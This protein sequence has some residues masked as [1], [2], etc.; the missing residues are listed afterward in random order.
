MESNIPSPQADLRNLQEHSFSPQDQSIWSHFVT[1][2]SRVVSLPF[3]GED[4]PIMSQ[5]I[6]ICPSDSMVT[7]SVL[8]LGA[9]HLINHSE[10]DSAEVQ[11]LVQTKDVL[12]RKV[13]EE[14]STRSASIRPLG[15]RASTNRE[16]DDAILASYILQYLHEMSEGTGHS[17]R[18]NILNQARSFVY[19]RLN[20]HINVSQSELETNL[21]SLKLSGPEFE[22]V[23]LDK[24]LL[25]LFAYHDIL[26]RVLDDSNSPDQIPDGTSLEVLRLGLFHRENIIG[27]H[28]GLMDI[29]LRVHILQC[30]TS[31]AQAAGGTVIARAVQIWQ[32]VSDWTIPA[33]AFNL[34]HMYEA[35]I[36]AISIWLLFIIY[37]GE[38]SEKVHAM[39]ARGLISLAEMD[40]SALLVTS[41]FPFYF[42]GLGCTTWP[43]RETLL[44]ELT[45]LENVQRLG[46]I[47]EFRAIL[48]ERWRESDEQDE[49][50]WSQNSDEDTPTP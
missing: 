36:A 15:K 20:K 25:Q 48:Y 29:I 13:Q 11:N 24:S 22:E 46:Y 34:S 23:G 35:Y 2:T 33:S 27:I 21:N 18:Q 1:V 28:H 30:E 45:R 49:E 16:E 47:R 32:T 44:G 19:P 5:I 26:A 37:S 8:C 31:A 6:S 3:E 4:D 14:M 40:E 43:D 38:S 7:S 12:L 9:S 17:P 39:V 10:P 41:V 50:S 42:I